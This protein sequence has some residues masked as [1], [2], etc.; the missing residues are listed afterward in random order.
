MKLDIYQNGRLL[1]SIESTDSLSP[2]DI[3]VVS[4]NVLQKSS[5]SAEGFDDLFFD[6]L[7]ESR[8]HKE[9]YFKAEEKHFNIF[10]TKRYTDFDSYRISKSN[11]LKK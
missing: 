2:T 7:K 9:A 3:A 5:I 6:S 11:R 10:G 1:Y 8:S 4:K